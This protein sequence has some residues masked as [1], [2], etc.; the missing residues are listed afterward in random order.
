[1]TDQLT[2][3]R[4]GNTWVFSDGTVLPVVSGG[5]ESAGAP[6]AQQGG[7]PQQGGGAP[8]GVPQGQEGQGQ[9]SDEYSLAAGFLGRIP[10][11]HRPI[12]EPYVK[13]WDAGVTRRFQ[14]LQS[15]LAPWQEIGDIEDVQAAMGLAQMLQENPYQVYGILHQALINGEIQAPEGQGGP[16]PLQQPVPN[17]V[18]PQQDQGLNGIPPEIS[19]RLDTMQQALVA[20][21]QHFLGQQTQQQTEA[22]NAEL[23]NYMAQLHEE[24][25]DF[26]DQYVMLQLYNGRSPDEAINNFNALI[27]QRA[28]QSLQRQN[29][30]PALLGSGGGGGVA[31]D[32]AS[33]KNLDRGQVRSLVATVLANAKQNAS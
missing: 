23:D 21:G 13:Q 19:Q 26:D 20:L 30:L 7:I 6:A 24:Y 3:E 8:S 32:P 10:E 4:I 22:E 18:P 27:T 12:V 25:G 9:G 29:G 11:E 5:D 28:S 31:S 1:M 15:Q 17:Q 33:V 16:G 14:E 2:F